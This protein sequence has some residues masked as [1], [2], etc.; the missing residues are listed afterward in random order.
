MYTEI[1]KYNKEQVNLKGC[2]VL[3]GNL[4]VTKATRYHNICMLI[5]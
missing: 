4:K 5:P 2:L 1:V 3:A